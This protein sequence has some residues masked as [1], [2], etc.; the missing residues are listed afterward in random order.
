MPDRAVLLIECAG[1]PGSG[2]TTFCDALADQPGLLRSEVLHRRLW[3]T[4]GG[5]RKLGLALSV[6][7]SEPLLCLDTVIAIASWGLWRKPRVAARL[8][9][10]PLQRQW[11]IEASAE[12]LAPPRCARLYDQGV[13]QAFWS[14]LDDAGLQDQGGRLLA[15]LVRR[16]YFGLPV[17]ILQFMVDHGSV[18][19]RIEGRVGGD[20]RFDGDTADSIAQRLRAGD[21]LMARLCAL[22]SELGIPLEPL[23]ATQTPAE[24]RADGLERIS[25]RLAACHSR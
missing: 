2:K 19:P 1:L 9:Q 15:R 3:A 23:S 4:L 11:M 24:V 7:W 21:G 12:P 13:L 17:V 18:A 6:L 22:A 10:V 8:L 5:R 20:S 16:T 25:R 14:I